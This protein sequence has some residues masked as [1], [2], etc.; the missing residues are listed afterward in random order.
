MPYLT[1]LSDFKN[2][3][4]IQ[5]RHRKRDE[6]NLHLKSKRRL[7]PQRLSAPSCRAAAP[8]ERARLNTIMHQIILLVKK[9][10]VIV[11]AKRSGFTELH[12][13]LK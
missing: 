6:P 12:A 1:R 10:L 11:T 8:F 3:P 5:A 13:I 9:N 4:Y 7:L 2:F